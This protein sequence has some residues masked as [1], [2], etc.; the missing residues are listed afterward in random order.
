M[1]LVKSNSYFL[2]V[3]SFLASFFLMM[4][5]LPHALVWLR[6]PFTFIF[7]MYWMLASPERC[8]LG[9]AFCVGLF[10]DMLVGTPLGLHALVFVLIGFFVL[11][12]A[13][14]VVHFSLWQQAGAVALLA[15]SHVLIQGWL[16]TWFDHRAFHI[17]HLLSAATT[18][19]IWPPLSLLLDRLRPRVLAHI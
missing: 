4:L 13:K 8:N 5:P 7:L 15:G 18:F 6:P 9:F 1:R 19:L 16:L 2:I 12:Y 3:T 14:A 10:L 11:K 17:V